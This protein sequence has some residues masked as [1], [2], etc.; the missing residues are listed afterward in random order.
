MAYAGGGR[1]SSFFLT[2]ASHERVR[3]AGAERREKVG[4]RWPL[5]TRQH[6]TTLTRD[7]DAPVEVASCRFIIYLFFWR[8]QQSDVVGVEAKDQVGSA[9]LRRRPGQAGRARKS[10]YQ[11]RGGAPAGPDVWFG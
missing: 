8:R 1:A 6:D 7:F 11:V 10:K 3:L 2:R 9:G 5:P 4:R